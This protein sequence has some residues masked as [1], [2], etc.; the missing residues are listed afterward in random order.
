M[1]LGDAEVDIA[2]GL[3]SICTQLSVSLSK[4]VELKKP[5]VAG[6][7]MPATIPVL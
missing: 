6:L 3:F 5:S 2:P 1:E 7:E 4:K